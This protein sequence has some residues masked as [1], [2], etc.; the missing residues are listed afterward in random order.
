M[1]TTKS[2][3]WTE[4]T[5]SRVNVNDISSR[6]TPPPRGLSTVRARL[7]FVRLLAHV[8]WFSC[9]KTRAQI[10]QEREIIKQNARL[11]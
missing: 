10:A 2:R 3:V 11:R 4:N 5:A 9:E 8:N 1:N 6:P 7:R